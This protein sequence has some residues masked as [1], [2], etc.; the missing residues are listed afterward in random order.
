MDRSISIRRSLLGNL[1]LVIVLLSGTIMITTFIGAHQA[2]RKLSQ[3]FIHQTIEQTEE[4]LQRFFDPVVRGLLLARTWGV[5]NLLDTDNPS[6]LNGLL[7][8]LMLQYPQIS[9]LLVADSRGREHMVLHVGNTWKNRQTRRDVWGDHTHWLE[10]TDTEPE[11]VASWKRLDYE[12]RVR[13]WYQG[14]VGSRQTE[15]GF[16]FSTDI[17][18]QVHWTKPYTFFTTKDPGI[19]ASVTFDLGDGLD[20]VVGFDVLLRDISMFTMSLQVRKHGLVFVLTDDGRIIGLPRDVRYTNLKERSAALLKLPNALGVPVVSDAV[21]ALTQRPLN[22]ARPQRFHS[23][24]EPWWGELKKFPLAANRTLSIVVVVPESDLLGGLHQFRMAIIFITLGVLG[25]AMVRTVMLARRY[26]RPIEA[27]ARESERIRRGDLE[28]GARIASP[29]REVH[30]LAE[31]H[32]RMRVAL[33]SLF[34]LERDLQIARHIQ[35]S[36]FPSR[37]PVLKGFDIAAWC[38]EAEAT[39]GDTYDIIG[40]HRDP[41][42]SALVLSSDHA[43]GAVLLLADA[44]GHGIGPALSVTEVRAML[45][46]ALRAGEDLPTLIQHL[47]A[48]LYADL[49]HGRFITTWL[50]LLNASDATLT[51]FSCGQA[52]LLYYDA[53]RGAWN[54]LRA[55]TMPLGIVEELDVTLPAPISMETGDLFAVLSDGIFETVDPAGEQFGSE[56]VM[57]LLAMFQHVSATEI[58]TALRDAVTVFTKGRPATDDR[59]AIIIKRIERIRLS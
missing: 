46:M 43:D 50:G 53:A 16:P 3:A 35:E 29:I 51:S 11:P 26:S 12:P 42:S 38:V 39:G 10:W 36:T 33:Q 22:P 27:L 24:G 1:S 52:P 15:A 8:P 25:V 32:E 47:N 21:Q 37:L 20:H 14:A 49:D 45:R 2:V 5:A 48:Q 55:D 9:S 7:V 23:S 30:R 57:D 34:K 31:T 4:R 44:T 19:T 17:P 13:P 59:T 56:R 28:P 40:Y 54:L 18:Q 6:A 58:V 41:N